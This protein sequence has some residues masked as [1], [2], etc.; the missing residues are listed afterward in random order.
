[1]GLW[2]SARDELHLHPLAERQVADG[3]VDEL[4]EVEQLDELVAGLPEIDGVEAVDRPDQL[5]RVERRAGPTGAG[6]GCP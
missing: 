5:E 6:C 1:M 3:L 2:S 4:A